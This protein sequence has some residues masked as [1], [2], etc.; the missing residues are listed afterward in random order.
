M[1]AVLPGSMGTGA[2]KMSQVLGMFGLLDFIML[3]SILDWWTF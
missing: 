1:E 3:W 2:K